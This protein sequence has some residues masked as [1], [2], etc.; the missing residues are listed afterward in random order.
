MSAEGPQRAQTFGEAEAQPS[1]GAHE[2]RKDTSPSL[3]P[4]QDTRAEDELLGRWDISLL[5]LHMLSSGHPRDQAATGHPRQ[6]IPLPSQVQ[7]SW[8]VGSALEAAC[9]AR[10][11]PPA[12][13][14]RWQAQSWCPLCSR[15]SRAG[16]RDNVGPRPPWSSRAWPV[17]PETH[18]SCRIST[19][20]D[21]NPTAAELG[22]AQG[23][24]GL[25]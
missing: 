14:R 25:A 24:M 8:D 2:A 4:C 10:G 12:R 9:S 23:G 15:G 13:G 20:L 16:G 11:R 7:G 5:Q 6:G 19:G 1:E 3:S 18:H 17:G 22:W 21:I